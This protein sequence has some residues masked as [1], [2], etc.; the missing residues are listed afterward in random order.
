M[1]IKMLRPWGLANVGDLLDPPIG[2]A[3]ELIARKVAEAVTDVQP[4]PGPAGWNKQFTKP[5]QKQEP[6]R[7][8]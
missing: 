1:K 4:K 7:G 5:P 8:K 3:L 6:R 2:V